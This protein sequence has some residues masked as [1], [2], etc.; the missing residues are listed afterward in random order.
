V[1]RPADD[2]AH[3]TSIDDEIVA[4]ATATTSME[5]DWLARCAPG[6][7]CELPI[8]LTFEP[9]SASEVATVPPEGVIAFD[10]VIEA[11][12]EDFAKGATV[13]AELELLER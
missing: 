13:P 9:I 3:R 10:W 5:R 12:F 11:R 4:S 6:S 2:D 7:D 1:E 8:T